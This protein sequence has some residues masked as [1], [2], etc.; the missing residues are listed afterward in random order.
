VAELTT[1]ADTTAS[2][3]C[4]PER[5]VTCCEPSE[6]EECCGHEDGCG[7]AAGVGLGDDVP[8]AR[9]TF[10][11]QPLARVASRY[12]RMARWYRFAGP[13][14]LLAPGF[15]RKAVGRLGLQ[16][17]DTVLEVGCGTGRNL[18]LLCDAVGDHGR[19]IGVDASAGM[20]AQARQLATRQGWKNVSLIYQDAAELALENQVD[21]VFFSLSYSVL[22][23][24]ARV[25]Q[26]AWQALRPGGRLVI[27]DAG[28]PA[29][30]L[31]RALGPFGEAIAT[32]FPGDPYSQPWEDLKAISDTVTTERFQLGIYFICRVVKPQEQS[33][34]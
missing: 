2:S 33:G 6:K 27:M 21:A 9:S 4:S 16:R 12:D 32:V 22:P 17:G 29:S 28:L 23:D 8:I 19:V 31:G 34:A 1:P 10:V 18:A 25:L 5:Q 15:R 7:C 3:C 30:P 13:L 24:R 14:I 20:L 11:R 26:K